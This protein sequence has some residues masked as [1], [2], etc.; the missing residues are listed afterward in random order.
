MA[1]EVYH[2]NSVSI[3]KQWQLLLIM[4]RILVMSHRAK[5][6][7]FSRN[8]ILSLIAI[9]ATKMYLTAVFHV[10]STDFT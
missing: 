7:Q 9:G 1:S 5:K 3:D 4:S 2:F 10:K 6:E 8:T